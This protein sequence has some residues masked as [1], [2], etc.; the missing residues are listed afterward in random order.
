MSIDFVYG[1]PGMNRPLL[2][3]DKKEE[4][5]NKTIMFFSA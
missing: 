2:P 3:E 1:T 5:L 4:N